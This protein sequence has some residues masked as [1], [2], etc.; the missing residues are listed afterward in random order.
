MRIHHLGKT[1]SVLQIIMLL[2]SQFGIAEDA[3][4]IEI[5][6]PAV[7][8]EDASITDGI[9]SL[10]GE[11][12][13]DDRLVIEPIDGIDENSQEGK[14]GE[15]AKTE[16]I[17]NA[18]KKSIKLGVKETY[19]LNINNATY[20]SSKKS[21]A[22]VSRNGVI[23]AKK[24]GTARI[25][26]KSGGKT[27][28]TVKVTVL[29]APKKIRLS[30][31]SK[32]MN[33]GEV[34]TLKAKLPSKTASKITWSSS[35]EEVA[36]VDGKGVV[37]ALSEGQAMITAETF[38][39][40]KASCIITVKGNDVIDEDSPAS[41][42]R[43]MQKKLISLG[44]LPSGGDTGKYDKATKEAVKRFQ[45]RVNQLAGYEVLEVTGIMDAQSQAFLDYYYEEWEKIKAGDGVINAYSSEED[46]IMVQRL[47]IEIGMLPE[48]SDTG[49]YGSDTIAA[50]ADFQQWVNEQRK[51]YTL[52][53]N[54]EVNQLTLLYLEYCRDHGLRPYGGT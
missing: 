37:T 8:E 6:D 49:I 16:I 51:E 30:K 35:D 11:I 32:K 15:A 25:T 38:N 47:L 39:G 48:G 4:Q 17:G 27:I 18:A 46:I 44:L 24:K 29:A 40:K 7:F 54:G 45:S 34:Y 50:V 53:V 22:T 5:A 1:I 2:F 14:S 3:L 21:V 52:E 20:K 33:I 26:V 10:S 43:S 28:G 23:T 31:T 42:I 9:E 36:E 12:I 13:L 41:V 19:E